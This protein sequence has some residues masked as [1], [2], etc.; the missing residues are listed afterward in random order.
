LARADEKGAESR[1][2][3]KTSAT[4]RLLAPLP[5]QLQATGHG[6]QVK[7]CQSLAAFR[8][9]VDKTPPRSLHRFV[10]RAQELHE[11]AARLQE[12]CARNARADGNNEFARRAEERAEKARERAR[13]AAED[14]SW[15]RMKS[16]EA[17]ARRESSAPPLWKR[18]LG[19]LPTPVLGAEKSYPPQIVIETSRSTRCRSLR[20][21]RQ[22]H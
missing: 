3:L 6:V 11:E 15:K 8:R 10:G 7:P 14:E 22:C 18:S 19:F 17:V 9:C 4:R 20:E 16:A 1:L 5:V 12:A 13:R 2:E 21:R